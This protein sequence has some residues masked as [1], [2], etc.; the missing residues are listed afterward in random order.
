[1]DIVMAVAIGAIAVVLAMTTL[2]SRPLNLAADLQDFALNARVTREW[3]MDR[4]LHYRLRVLSGTPYQYV[5]EQG[6][7]TGAPWWTSPTVVRTVT[8]RQNIAFPAGTQGTFA[9]F[10]TRG[11]SVFYN[12]WVT[13]VTFTLQDVARG[14]TKTVTVSSAGMV[15]TP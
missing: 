11:Q 10:D 12:P 3:A 2:T 13:S 7:L 15:G 5:I 6:S 1:M 8:L 9:E 4:N 14:W